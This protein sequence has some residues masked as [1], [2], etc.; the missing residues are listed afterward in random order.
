MNLAPE[1]A[2]R[3]SSRHRSRQPAA[4]A[5]GR[6]ARKDLE[7][8]SVGIE[9]MAHRIQRPEEPQRP[10]LAL[11]HSSLCEWNKSSRL[12]GYQHA[13]WSCALIPSETKFMKRLKALTF[14]CSLKTITE[15]ID[16]RRSTSEAILSLPH[17]EESGS[18][19][20]C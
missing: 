8:P 16:L 15:V 20:P 13:K 2:P 4:P 9:T 14:D 3:H 5:L 18:Y 10:R 7:Q 12:T 17:C 6:K 1:A 11:F 19:F